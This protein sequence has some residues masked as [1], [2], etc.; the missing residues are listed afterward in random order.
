MSSLE[1]KVKKIKPITLSV[2]RSN[3]PSYEN[4]ENQQVL[5]AA[6]ADV[7]MALNSNLHLEGVLDCILESLARVI[8]YKTANI[9][10]IEGKNARIV[11]SNG[12]DQLG[13][14]EIM[15]S[16]VF[17]FTQISFF[18]QMIKTKQPFLSY[19]PH[20]EQNWNSLAES[21]WIKSHIAAPIFLEDEMIGFLNCDSDIADFFT[22]NQLPT[23]QIF[24][25]EAGLAIRNARLF[26]ASTKL[27]K[28]LGLINDLTRQVLKATTVNQIFELLPEKL[29][30]L[31]EGSN[32]YISKWDES[33]RMVTGWAATGQTRDSFIEGHASPEEHTLTRELLEAQKPMVIED[34]SHSSVMDEKFH[35]LYQE[36]TLFC[37][38]LIAEEIKFGA[39]IIGFQKPDQ[40]TEDVRSLGEYAAAQISTAVAKIYLL[41][42]ER[43]QSSQLAHANAL[44]E[45]L[46]R[47]STAIKSGVDTKN[48]MSTIGSELEALKIHSAVALRINTTDS[49]ALT[50]SSVQSNI[51]SFAKKIG[52]GKINDL[53][54][55]FDFLPGLKNIIENQ[56]AQY[57]EDPERILT[58]IA[59]VT[60]KPIIK[61]LNEALL[62]TDN[63]NCILTPLVV[64]KKSIGILC[65]WGEVLQKIDIQAASIFGGQVAIAIENANLLQEVQRL[66]ITDELT[67]VLNRRG[68]IE[69]ANHEFEAAKRYSRPLSLIMLDIDRFKAINDVYGH[70][71]GDEILVEIAAR[72]RTKIRET[73]YIS[74]YGGEEFLILLI[75]QKPENAR[76]VA[77][78]I[79]KS[80]SDQ[81]FDTSVG[82]ISV[83]IS[84]GVTGASSQ[85]SSISMMIK[86][87]DKALYKS[88]ENGRNRVTLIDKI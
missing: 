22:K 72:A 2:K 13:T 66:A 25:S 26:D 43:N 38:P 74:R 42:L 3:F 53:V 61:K 83:T 27:S 73:D 5:T 32:V 88:K 68:F 37:L 40:I 59:P 39:I 57:F 63:S 49:L 20:L 71:I 80:V 33:T 78:R 48:V 54:A 10:L 45:S 67:N 60:I 7:S 86:T 31:S 64:E 15:L 12:Y 24:A 6:L 14:K 36:K 44:I 51:I 58:Q 41:E 76:T 79:R 47:V 21:E 29:V 34:I 82:K 4:D 17:D 55:P 52:G 65:L 50:Y 70:P 16:K 8:D 75:E 1:L 35:S 69:T 9:M 18:I 84:V 30:E 28:K 85:I 11:R 62:L 56:Q 46:S 23:M 87:V 77:E 19:Y 81:P